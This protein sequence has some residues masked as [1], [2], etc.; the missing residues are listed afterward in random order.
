MGLWEYV[1]FFWIKPYGIASL[2]IFKG[3]LS[4]NFHKYW[5]MSIKWFYYF[6][7]YIMKQQKAEVLWLYGRAYNTVVYQ[8]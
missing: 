4:L 7:M 2:I 3:D 1:V 8:W 6:F 5:F